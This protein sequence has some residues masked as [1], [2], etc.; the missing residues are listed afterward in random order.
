[1]AKR[2]R[3][4]DSV[5]LLDVPGQMKEFAGKTGRVVHEEMLGRERYYRIRMDEPVNIPGLGRVTDDLWTSKFI[6]KVR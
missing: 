4:G 1:M 2:L 5:L 6:R 3:T